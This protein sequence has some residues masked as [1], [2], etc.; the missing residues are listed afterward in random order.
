MS[1]VPV[2]AWLAALVVALVVLAFCAYEINWKS[3]R[4]R[5][6]L[7]KLQALQT[8]VEGLQAE[9]AAV[10]HRVAAAQADLTAG[11]R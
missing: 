2:A 11:R 3:R 7:A 4:L 8:S 6:D 10:Q 9:V 5:D 1:W